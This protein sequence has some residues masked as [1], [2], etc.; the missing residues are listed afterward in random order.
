MQ[1]DARRNSWK[2]INDNIRLHKELETKKKEIGRRHEELE[3]L[4]MNSTNREK[5][6]AAKEEVGPR[7]VF[8][9]CWMFLISWFY[10]KAFICFL[11]NS[12]FVH[13][14]AIKCSYRLQRRTGFSI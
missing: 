3:K 5:L 12:I 2:I 8:Q 14:Y 13:M 7:Y 9:Y 1:K 11:F 10:H 6:E 4:V